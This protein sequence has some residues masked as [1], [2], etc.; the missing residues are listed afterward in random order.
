VHLYIV[1]GASY[2]FFYEQAFRRDE[3]LQL[4]RIYSAEAE[5]ARA[6]GSSY[7]AQQLGLRTSGGFFVPRRQAGPLFSSQAQC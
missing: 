6:V 1:S 2:S 5:V 3:L 4:L 7:L